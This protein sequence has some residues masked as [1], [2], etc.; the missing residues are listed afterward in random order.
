MEC[1]AVVVETFPS[2]DASFGLG[3]CGTSTCCIVEDTLLVVSFVDPGTTGITSMVV[4]CKSPRST[5]RQKTFEIA[6]RLD[7]TRG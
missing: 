1:L 6:F 5:S 4:L 7:V 3:V 2:S